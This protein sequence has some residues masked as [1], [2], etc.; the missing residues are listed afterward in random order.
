MTTTTRPYYL[1]TGGAGGIGFET[2][3]SLAKAGHPVIL[4]ARSQSKADEA[5]HRLKSRHPALHLTL[6]PLPLDLCDFD[7]IESLC[8]ELDR[9]QIVLHCLI[10]NAGAASTDETVSHG[11]SKLWINNFLGH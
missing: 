1:I 3:S 6:L 2:A 8:A 9:R 7:S 5:A 11:L 10:C 4:T